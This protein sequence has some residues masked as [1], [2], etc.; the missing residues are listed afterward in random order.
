MLK[1]TLILTLTFLQEGMFNNAS[2]LFRIQNVNGSSQA[3]RIDNRGPGKGKRLPDAE[4]AEK[5]PTKKRTSD[6]A[7]G[8]P[9][10][11]D[12]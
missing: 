1:L 11:V 6:L 5:R 7:D 9:M 4:T 3:T 8:D 12:S 10:E 2:V